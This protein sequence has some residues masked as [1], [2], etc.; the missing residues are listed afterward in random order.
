MA[1]YAVGSI[2]VGNMNVIFAENLVGKSYRPAVAVVESQSQN[3]AS[4][5]SKGVLFCRGVH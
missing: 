4:A 5:S 1:P 3:L 2:A